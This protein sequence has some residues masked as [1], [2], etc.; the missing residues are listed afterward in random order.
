MTFAVDW[1]FPARRALERVPWPKSG[2]VAAL[3]YRFAAGRAPLLRSGAWT[4]RGAGYWIRMRVDENAR[5]VLVL[6]L[7]PV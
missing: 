1:D 4:V 3:V 7:E 5:T 2:E 6:Y